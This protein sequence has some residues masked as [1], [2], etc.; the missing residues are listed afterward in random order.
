VTDTEVELLIEQTGT[1]VL[2]ALR[3][4]PLL[5]P[6]PIPEDNWPA[7]KTLVA[8]FAAIAVEV[9][10]FSEQIA[11]QVSPYPYL[12]QM[13]DD[14]LS[15]KQGELGIQPPKTG[16]SLSLTDLIASQYG[17]AIYNFPD[18]PMVNWMTPL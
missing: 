1:L 4:D 13:F 7:V 17:K 18:D 15:Q 11:R 3:W 9:T 16:G 6:L 2:A 12:K 8:L 5:D 14:M 10:K